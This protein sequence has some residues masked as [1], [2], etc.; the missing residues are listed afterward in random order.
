MTNN[1]GGGAVGFRH[2]TYLAPAMLTLLLPVIAGDYK[3][4][5]VGGYAVAGLGAFS[6]IVLLLFAVRNPWEVLTLD[7][8]QVGTWQNYLPIVAKVVSGNLLNP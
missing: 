6:M 2:A 1:F 3:A 5:H 4:A 7:N 8:R